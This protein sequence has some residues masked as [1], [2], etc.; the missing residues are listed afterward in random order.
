MVFVFFSLLEFPR[1]ALAY[2]V[3]EYLKNVNYFTEP[4]SDALTDFEESEKEAEV[5]LCTEREAYKTG[6][7]SQ[8]TMYIHMHTLTFC[9][10]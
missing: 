8:K 6:E 1:L 2:K 5:R 10:Q 9:L 7:L 4:F 3:L